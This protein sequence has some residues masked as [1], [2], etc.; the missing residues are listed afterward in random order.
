VFLLIPREPRP[1]FALWSGRRLLAALD[2]LVW[3]SAAVAVVAAVPLKVG[4]FGAV[5]IVIATHLGVR[6][7]YRAL[8]MNHRYR[9]TTWTWGKRLAELL[10]LGLLLKLAL[11]VS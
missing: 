10:L 4:A 8:W 1:D 9:F 3:P 5:V 7:L 2:A 6:R 11:H